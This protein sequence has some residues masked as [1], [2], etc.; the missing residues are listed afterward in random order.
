MRLYPRRTTLGFCSMLAAIAVLYFGTTPQVLHGFGTRIY[1]GTSGCT[2][3]SFNCGG[4]PGS[5]CRLTSATACS[6][7]SAN[8]DYCCDTT[9]ACGGCPLVDHTCKTGGC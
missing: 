8:S 5:A 4:S 9:G 3:T 2:L 1:G 6:P 7:S